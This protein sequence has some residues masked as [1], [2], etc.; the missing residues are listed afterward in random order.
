MK[1]KSKKTIGKDENKM[2]VIMFNVIENCFKSCKV[3]SFYF[4][5]QDNQVHLTGFV[6][7]YNESEVLIAHITPRGE[8]DGFILNRISDVYRIDCGGE[9]EIKIQTLYE[10]KKESHPHISC[11]EEGILFPLL[12][13][14]KENDYFITAEL[15]NDKVTGRVIEYGDYIYLS[16]IDDNGYES[17]TSIIDVDEVVS[18]SC[19][20]VY[21]QD[22][23]ILLSNI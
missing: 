20:T 21:E 19:D 13:F 8:Y 16:T 11:N 5:K 14:A 22:L 3:A 18:F 6:H 12:A 4:D 9:Y 2:E 17:G 15:Q 10:L 1:R 23:K 7:C